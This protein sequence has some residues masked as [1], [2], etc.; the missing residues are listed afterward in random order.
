[1]IAGE[2]LSMDMS[3]MRFVRNDTDVTPNTGETSASNS[4]TKAGPPLRA[5]SALAYQTLLGLASTTLGLPVGSLTVKSG[6]VS[7]GGKSVSYGALIGGKLFNVQAPASYNMTPT[8]ANPPAAGPGVGAGAPGTKPVSSY[9]LVGT[10]PVR[11]DIPD[12]VT[13]SYTY[14]QN[15]RVPGMLHGRRVLPRGQS[16]FGF[17]APVVSIDEASISHI[18]GARVVRANNFVGVVAA[19]EY[20]AIQAAAQLKVVWADPPRSLPGSGNTYSAMRA[21]DTAGQ[22]VQSIRV[23]TGD[24]GAGFASAAHVSAQTYEFPF[25]SLHGIGPQ[26]AVADVT[27][28]GAVIFCSSSNAHD[29]TQAERG[30]GNPDQPSSGRLLRELELL[31]RR[32]AGQPRHPPSGGNY[33]PARR[34]AGTSPAHALGR[35]RLGRLL[36]R[37]PRRHSGRRRRQRQPRCLR[38]SRVLSAI[39]ELNSIRHH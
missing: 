12:K 7:G 6:V 11:I 39:Q 3:Q 22:S 25:Q 5:A 36:A 27:S 37:D 34:K 1:M 28:K 24:L 9:T 30:L 31:W 35:D 16:V 26:C 10:S 33:V 4:I 2:E 15:V 17:N 23:N 20:D 21:Q 14:V 8:T 29:D 38:H 32:P 18:P 13:G 19:K